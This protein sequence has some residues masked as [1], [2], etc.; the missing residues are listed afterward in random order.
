MQYILGYLIR[1]G[2]QSEDVRKVQQRLIDLGY[3]CGN[4]GAD[5]IFG[6][7]TLEAVKR[8]QRDNGL[9][10]DGIVG[11]KTWSKLFC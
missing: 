2:Q 11:N 9:S 6:N 3:S 7:G 4:C 8:F 10:I 5:S 1:K